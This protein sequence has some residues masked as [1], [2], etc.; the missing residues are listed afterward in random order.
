MDK[1]VKPYPQPYLMGIRHHG[2]GSARS[3][4]SALATL[5]PEILLV[6]GPPEGQDLLTWTA[7]DNLVP[8]VAMLIYRP[9]KPSEAAYYPFALFSPE[10]Q[11]VQ[12]ARRLDVPVRFIDLPQ[13]TQFAMNGRTSS[14]QPESDAE[15]PNGEENASSLASVHQDPLAWIAAAAGYGDSE[16]WWERQIEERQDS[17]HLFSAI[18]ELMLA[19]RSEVAT[20]ID[21]E[22]AAA[23]LDQPTTNL[24]REAAMR[25]AIRGA[26]DE[27][28]SQVAV[29]CGAWHTPA[30]MDLEDQTGDRALLARLPSVDVAATWVP[31]TYQRLALRSGYGAGIESPG[32][33]H[34]L[35]LTQTQT[36]SPSQMAAS[37]LTKTAQLM[38][39][40][41]LTIS[42]AHIIEAVRLA[43]ALAA[44][45][46]RAASG[47][48]ELMEA[49]QSI[50]CFGE[51]LPITLVH[52]RLLIGE[53]LGAVPS[54]VPTVPLQAD[55]SRLQKRLRLQPQAAP[56]DLDLDLRKPMGLGRSRL[57]HR[58]SLLDIHW[59]V[60]LPARSG[61][62]TFH[63]NWKLEWSPELAVSV[64]EASLWGNSVENAADT[65]ARHRVRASNSLAELTSLAY[66]FLLANL[67]AALSVALARVAEIAA[68][69]GDVHGL[70]AAFPPLVRIQ[71]YGDVRGTEVEMVARVVDGLVAR[72]CIGLPHACMGIA[73]EV[74]ET[75]FNQLNRMHQS[76]MLLESGSDG[77]PPQGKNDHLE[78]WLSVL[79]SI[80]QQDQ[81][82]TLIVGRA[83][84][85]LHDRNLYD[86]EETARQLGVSLSAASSPLK[87]AQ[88]IDGFLRASG[89]ILIYD[90]QLWELIDQ[91]VAGLAAD[92]F[93]E[94][95]PVLR[96]TF[97]TFTRPERRRLGELAA[98]GGNSISATGSS[99]E[100]DRDRAALAL[101]TI[102]Q[103]LGLRLEGADDG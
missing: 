49:T 20:E 92:R 48:E 68:V 13:A 37:W 97:A 83:C 23:K 43:E 45:R 14:A 57:L 67:P 38:R 40:E 52:D 82:H 36:G 62:G 19:L 35:W 47:L 101:P 78:R 86:G 99:R 75:T 66:T 59:G 7:D 10:W 69:A 8:P 17:R 11:A 60:L 88:W 26:Y 1:R 74:A 94:I 79:E 98:A 16:R 28:Y 5:Q 50:F 80:A 71:R 46:G 72:I 4:R 44:L 31:W 65:Q 63:E 55:L 54:G 22:H 76:I 24:L 58:L 12:G 25:E 6:E 39:E 61:R 91:W 34:H 32:W 33:Y 85:L 84:R 90:R 77:R 27:G 70:M 9:K 3:V 100:F 2:P 89:T 64:I 56:R 96:R 41:G 18:G 73:D 87:A 15:C 51:S 29:V 21:M 53:R 102:A 42:P 93:I 103:L 30:L 95:L 81:A